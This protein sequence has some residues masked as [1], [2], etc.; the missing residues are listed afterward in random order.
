VFGPSRATDTADFG[1]PRGIGALSR[2]DGDIDTLMQRLAGVRVWSYIAARADWVK[3]SPHWQGRAREVEDLLSDALHE[4]LTSRF[5]DRR[6]THLMRRLDAGETQEL[7]SAVSRRGEGIVEGHPVGRIAGF[8]FFPTRRRGEEAARDARGDGP[9]RGDAAP[10]RRGRGQPDGNWIGGRENTRLGPRADPRLKTWRQRVRG[11]ACRC[12][13][14]VPRRRAAR[15][16]AHQVAA[17]RRR[18]GEP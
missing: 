18:H 9:A 16:A 15:A 17:L 2:A 12:W 8:R 13:Q 4:R 3:D 10:C 1:W 5:V 11:A 14:R 6:A 7:L